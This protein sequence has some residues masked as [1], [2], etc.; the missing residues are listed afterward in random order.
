MMAREQAE[1][2]CPLK[3][4]GRSNHALDGGFEV[5]VTIHDDGVLAP[6]LEDGALD[7]PLGGSGCAQP[8]RQSRA[9]PSSSHRLG[10]L[11]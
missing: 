11:K 4:K 3:P 2:F 10:G 8:T 9:R 7:E 1:H 5:R 6:H